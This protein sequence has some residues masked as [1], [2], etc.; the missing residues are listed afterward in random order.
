[1]ESVNNENILMNHGLT[2]SMNVVLPAGLPSSTHYRFKV[3]NRI[4]SEE[5]DFSDEFE[6]IGYDCDTLN[7][8]VTTW[9]PFSSNMPGSFAHGSSMDLHWGHFPGSTSFDIF[10]V[11]SQDKWF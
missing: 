7:L 8:C 9:P 11:V 4:D 10:L 5:F 1:M 2:A 6:V 3:Q